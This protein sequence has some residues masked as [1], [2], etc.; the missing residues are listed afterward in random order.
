MTKGHNTEIPS[1]K[2][3]SMHKCDMVPCDTRMSTG[4]KSCKY[5]WLQETQAGLWR[6]GEPAPSFCSPLHS[7]GPH[8]LSSPPLPAH[9]HSPFSEQAFAARLLAFGTHNLQLHV[10][11][12]ASNLASSLHYLSDI[13]M[14][15]RLYL[16]CPGGYQSKPLWLQVSGHLFFFF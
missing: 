15:E 10:A 1:Y 13:S 16:T 6:T 3:K 5:M 11:T 2:F 4:L 12:I 14:G 9:L 8:G 7:L